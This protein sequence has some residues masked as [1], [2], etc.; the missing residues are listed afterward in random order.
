MISRKI[1][2]LDYN[3]KLEITF[4]ISCKNKH[5]KALLVNATLREV[6]VIFNPKTTWDGDHLNKIKYLLNLTLWHC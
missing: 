5:R 1:F 3:R 2:T 4:A 6:V